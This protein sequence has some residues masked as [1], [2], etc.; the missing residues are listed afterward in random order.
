[1][2]NE[3]KEAHY[4]FTLSSMVDLIAEHGYCNVMNDLD[5]MIANEVNKKLEVLHETV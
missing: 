1:M 5:E 3:L 2:L 4:H